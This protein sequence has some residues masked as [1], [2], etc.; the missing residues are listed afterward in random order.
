M[1][2]FRRKKA[3]TTD[4]AVSQNLA[5]T[6]D[7]GTTTAL[8]QGGMTKNKYLF[9]ADLASKPT[10]G[11]AKLK[12]LDFDFYVNSIAIGENTT[13]YPEITT[14]LLK[15]DTSITEGFQSRINDS[16][17]IAFSSV[18]DGFSSMG[19]TFDGSGQA[20]GDSA[21]YRNIARTIFREPAQ[22]CM[23]SDAKEHGQNGY[24]WRHTLDK[25]SFSEIRTDFG[26]KASDL[27]V[28]DT[29]G[30]A[31]NYI[32][33]SEDKK[34]PP[35]Q[36][37]PHKTY[38][39]KCLPNEAHEGIGYEIWIPDE[40]CKSGTTDMSTTDGYGNEATP[41]N[42]IFDMVR[43]AA[44]FASYDTDANA[45]KL[46]GVG[47]PRFNTENFLSAPHSLELYTY[48]TGDGTNKEKV[49]Y[50]PKVYARGGAPTYTS[51]PA[52]RQ[53]C[54]L[55][56]KNIP[57]PNTKAA[58]P[59]KETDGVTRT[60]FADISA[61]NFVSEGHGLTANT[62][63][64]IDDFDEDVWGSLVGTSAGS[65]VSMETRNATAG[66]Y[67]RNV[68]D[69]TFQL[70]AS[71]IDGEIYALSGGD[72]TSLK[73]KIPDATNEVIGANEA[74]RA[75]AI[76]ADY[77]Y[78]PH[79]ATIEMDVN[80]KKL[81]KA[82]AYRSDAGKIY[83]SNG[84]DSTN[85]GG[86]QQYLTLR[87][88]FHVVFGTEAPEANDTLF[89]YIAR[90]TALHNASGSSQFKITG[91][92]WDGVEGEDGS[93]SALWA[94]RGSN[95]HSNS[96]SQNP[97]FGGFS[98]LNT[99]HGIQVIPFNGVQGTSTA[100]GNAPT[101]G[102]YIPDH[103]FHV[104]ADASASTAA[105]DLFL[106]QDKTTGSDIDDTG[107]TGV[108]LSVGL[109]DVWS[110]FIIAVD[111]IASR[112]S[113]NDD[114]GG[115]GHFSLGRLYI[116]DT[117]GE[118][119]KLGHASSTAGKNYLDLGL[120]GDK[121]N[122]YSY[123]TNKGKV[124]GGSFVA[125]EKYKITDVA[126][127]DWSA[128]G[129]P[130]PASVGDI[131]VATAGGSTAGNKATSLSQ[132]PTNWPKHM[133]IWLTNYKS[134]FVDAHEADEL[135]T[136]GADSESKVLIDQIQ[137]KDFNY[138]ITNSS[139]LDGQKITSPIKIETGKSFK[140]PQGLY[141]TFD[142]NSTYDGTNTTKIDA[143][144]ST[145]PTLLSIGLKNRDY[146]SVDNA[147]ASAGYFPWT[148]WPYGFWL[149]DF[150]ANNL[151]KVGTIPDDHIKGT[152][153]MSAY[154]DAPDIIPLGHQFKQK[155]IDYQEYNSEYNSGTIIQHNGY[156]AYDDCTAAGESSFATG[157]LNTGLKVNASVSS[158]G[159]AND[160]SEKQFILAQQAQFTGSTIPIPI[161][162]GDTVRLVES[163]S[164]RGGSSA[165]SY[166]YTVA[167]VTGAMNASTGAGSSLTFT[168][169]ENPT[170][171]GDG[172]ESNADDWAA[173]YAVFVQTP[174]MCRNFSQKGGFQI[175]NNSSDEH[176]AVKRENIAASA[177]V[178]DIVESDAVSATIVADCMTPF[179]L[180]DDEEYVAF[181]YGDAATFSDTTDVALPDKIAD[182]SANA[183]TGLKIIAK[184]KDTN[185][186]TF[187]WDGKD[188][189]G[190]AML[191]YDN[192]HKLYI[193]PWRYWVQIMINLTDSSGQELSGR[194]YGNI[195][196]MN[197]NWVDSSSNRR[198]WFGDG[199]HATSSN[200]F[201]DTDYSNRTGLG[202]TWNEW[203]FNDSTTGGV[204]GAYLNN[205]N[206]DKVPEHSTIE[207]DTDFGFGTY[208]DGN[209]SGGYTG[210]VIVED[211]KYNRIRMPE[212]ISGANLEPTDTVKFLLDYNDVGLSHTTTLRTKNDTTYPPYLFTVFED[213]KP[214]NPSLTV[215]PYEADPFLPEFNWDA[216]DD[217][218]WYGILHIDS[219]SIN[220]Q[221]HNGIFHMPMN[222]SGTHGAT[223]STTGDELFASNATAGSTTK[224]A[225]F[226][227]TGALVDAEGL[228]GN[229]VRFDGSDD[230]ITYTASSNEAFPELDTAVAS[231]GTGAAS[232]VVHITPNNGIDGTTN[233]VF[234][235]KP[236]YINYDADNGKIQARC[237]TTASAYVA[238]EGPDIIT[239]GQTPT[240]IIVT[241]DNSL[242]SGNCKLFIN[243]AVVDQSG[244]ISSSAPATDG[245]GRSWHNSSGTPVVPFVA[246]TA[247]TVG[248]ASNSF[249]G[250]I[251]ELVIYKSCIYPIV[252]SNGK[253]VLDKA[254]KEI[255]NETPISYNA[256][257][258]VKDYHNI[259]GTT[260]DE[261]A[262]S[263]S[264][265]YRKAAFRLK[266]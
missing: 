164:Y 35:L 229:C 215:K 102:L 113:F 97:C 11:N 256:R 22:Y 151:A 206:L 38:W 167:T 99:E 155:S 212:I 198:S 117:D 170:L 51:G 81:A 108:N 87:R 42:T 189:A 202:T 88:G 236:F 21:T 8:I 92:G 52:N 140:A 209:N 171:A 127:S 40:Y 143:Y 54:V 207:C 53:E 26:V 173:G 69:D 214:N 77:D 152:I 142:R 12:S 195:Q 129:G 255:N 67:V 15:G 123:G 223:V 6:F 5:D 17:I 30:T 135:L 71:T 115:R 60:V 237:Y 62:V 258:F 119:T 179:D 148:E 200:N 231:G 3:I 86:S 28:V 19:D 58:M 91:P 259:R 124:S 183:K 107:A 103:D 219:K 174:G 239:D 188:N 80:I 45:T 4:T 130:S 2:E 265:S 31:P 261:V 266:D 252:P 36:I 242:K 34:H 121:L 55:V 65:S 13:K 240:C 50:D 172:G 131:F 197:N 194:Q 201:V 156:L 90:M 248:A 235:G 25:H 205:W 100:S 83:A 82:F 14:F 76:F 23:V 32:R 137:F 73:I 1:V 147:T 150:S 9:Q 184:D 234:D 196:L 230:R 78:S 20:Y 169:E 243:G 186:I 192:I 144:Y 264:V 193:S 109:E 199:L 138:E 249:L 204:N 116:T 68:A 105:N 154:T 57:Y 247:V 132:D 98:V 233:V 254:L 122:F 43:G 245:T 133:S 221:Y 63:V 114:H 64:Y 244:L 18:A 160:V 85:Q 7:G 112:P 111:P 190:T 149:N 220:S 74:L 185:S 126:G 47:M 213:E 226:T 246:S 128:W 216:N 257:L 224:T 165:R 260:T 218:L 177:R 46:F 75:D 225:L 187:D 175:Y 27:G 104:T 222:E 72:N 211:S 16:D 153:S 84:T 29:E 251:E 168:V 141:P 163:N 166:E 118:I 203:L 44:E 70:S 146:L 178:I 33:V 250:R 37:G 134:E 217:D 125:G 61:N 96:T 39:R 180:E 181:L 145:T 263:S 24:K 41:S 241:I 139:Q 191:T 79:A 120:F 176:S 161:R 228:A 159:D 182:N 106:R 56:K 66:H 262:A 158:D 210:R 136:A 253:F 10:F 49:T 48:W 101:F 238:L 232:I 95:N 227:Y 110:K 208:D 94:V 157:F 59:S 93:E 162:V 89:D